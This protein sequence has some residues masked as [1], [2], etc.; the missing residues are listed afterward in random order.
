[1]NETK[2]M[3]RLR[4]EVSASTAIGFVIV[5]LG[6]LQIF[7]GTSS[8]DIAIIVRGFAYVGL[9][10]A[11]A[12]SGIERLLNFKLDKIH[13]W[14]GPHEIKKQTLFDIRGNILK[15]LG[16]CANIA[17]T[18]LLISVSLGRFLVTD[19]D[20][21]IGLLALG[22]VFS[23]LGRMHTDSRKYDDIAEGINNMHQHLEVI[24]YDFGKI[25]ERLANIDRISDEKNLKHDGTDNVSEVKN[26]K[27]P[28][29]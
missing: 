14:L 11:G 17:G 7:I 1:M 16:L 10:V 23:S 20:L 4:L 6:V 5:L 13:E 25:Q 8:S 18:I 2:K 3:N 12:A 26:Q 29:M 21:I 19:G 24:Q 15:F 9:G 28:S 27:D 22:L